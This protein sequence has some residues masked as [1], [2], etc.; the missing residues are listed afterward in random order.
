MLEIQCYQEFHFSTELHNVSF[1][2]EKTLK[3]R[4]N[5]GRTLKVGNAD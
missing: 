5:T 4:K 3:I 2:I 1:E